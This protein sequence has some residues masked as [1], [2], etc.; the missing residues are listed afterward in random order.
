M[1]KLIL[2]QSFRSTILSLTRIITLNL[3]DFLHT[4]RW[5]IVEM[6]N[7]TCA[8]SVNTHTCSGISTTH[9]Y[10][11]H[12]KYYFVMMTPFKLFWIYTNFLLFRIT[13]NMQYTYTGLACEVYL[14]G[15]YSN[16]GY[17]GGG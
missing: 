9:I 8:D 6:I 14:R 5:S 16:D 3:L 13:A 12:R 7:S 17:A 1:F 4:S 15:L 10:G 11:I 2:N